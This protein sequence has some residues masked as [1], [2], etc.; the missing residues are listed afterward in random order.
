MKDL[1]LSTNEFG[2]VAGE[3]VLPE[4]LRNGRFSIKIKSGSV[5]TD[6]Y[7]RVDEFVLPTFDLAFDEIE[8]L[9]LPGDTV[10]ISGV[11]RSYSSHSLSSAKALFTSVYAGDVLSEG[12]LKIAADGR[13]EILVPSSSDDWQYINTN[14]KIID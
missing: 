1:S 8:R 13:F 10:K 9:Y 3:F 12:S 5:E 14:V 2:A 6:D 7:F 4:G 11:V